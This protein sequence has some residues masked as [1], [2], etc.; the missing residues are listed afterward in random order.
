M[1]VVTVSRQFGSGGDEIAARVCEILAYGYFD[2]KL[3]ARVAN[4][5]GLSEGEI[6]DLSEDDYRVRGFMDRLLRRSPSAG[7]QARSW[8]EDTTGVRM[9]EVKALDEDQAV[10]LVRAS[11]EA[12]YRQGNIVIVGRGGQVVL[13]DKPAVL[14]VRIQAPFD[15]RARR[16]A[17]QE[18][19]VP[20]AAQDLITGRD[21]AAASYLKRFHDVDWADPGLYHLVLNTAKWDVEG[22]ARVIANAATCL[23]AA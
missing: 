21:K 20:S 8:R 13:R 3:L 6:V 15:V 12:A 4:E 14:H 19:I 1:A 5:V 11:I 7:A 16:V 9:P 2:K 18:R 17:E 10:A 22:A 23:P